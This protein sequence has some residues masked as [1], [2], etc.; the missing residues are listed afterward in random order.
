MITGSRKVS[1]KWENML[2]FAAFSFFITGTQV[3]LQQLE[4]QGGLWGENNML[5]LEHQERKT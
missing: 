2:F 1:L 3:W 5:M 4:H